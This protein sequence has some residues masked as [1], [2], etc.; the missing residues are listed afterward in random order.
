MSYSPSSL[1]AKSIHNTCAKVTPNLT[2][3]IFTS[4]TT[5]NI[6]PKHQPNAN[7]PRNIP[8]LMDLKLSSYH[9]PTP[10][11]SSSTSSKSSSIRSID[12]SLTLVLEHLLP[13][14]VNYNFIVSLI[15][16]IKL[17]HS[18]ITSASFLTS[19]AILRFT[20]ISARDLCFSSL[21]KISPHSNLSIYLFVIIYLTT[22]LLGKVLYHAL[23]QKLTPILYKV[24][25]NNRS[26]TFELRDKNILFHIP[27]FSSLKNG[28]ILLITIRNH[29]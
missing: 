5:I 11:L 24:F 9:T 25:F 16:Y 7:T 18:Y 8:K 1:T 6:Q 27:L 4:T 26:Q 22:R 23:K 15:N 13:F 10:I 28:L 2:S 21:L 29:L 19:T 12:N 3:D 20:N 17:P 14:E